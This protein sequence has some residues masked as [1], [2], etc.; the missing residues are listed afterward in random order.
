MY[1]CLIR[2]CLIGKKWQENSHAVDR[3]GNRN[4][5]CMSRRKSNIKTFA[6][7][8]IPSLGRR[9]K[10]MD[11][12]ISEHFKAM[13]EKFQLPNLILFATEDLFRFESDDAFMEFSLSI[14]MGLISQTGIV[15]DRE[16]LRKM[17]TEHL[18]SYKL[19]SHRDV[20][21]NYDEVASELQRLSEDPAY[22]STMR[23]DPA[24]FLR[25]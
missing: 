20:I 7:I 12:H 19:K 18:H 8:D 1:A 15:P 3:D 6:K 25:P 5:A 21:Y 14:W 23:S 17:F 16:E 24:D 9:L 22:M 13:R 4:D 11:V 10:D 2:D